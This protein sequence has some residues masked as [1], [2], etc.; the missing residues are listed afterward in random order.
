[1]LSGLPA[2]THLVVNG[3]IFSNWDLVGDIELPS[4][5]PCYIR[6]TDD[7]KLLSGLL[8][9][10]RA[11]LLQTLFLDA[12]IA[13]EVCDL[14]DTWGLPLASPKYPL[15]NSFV[16]FLIP[17]RV[18]NRNTLCWRDVM[19]A[20]PTVTHFTLWADTIDSFLLALHPLESSVTPLWLDYTPSHWSI[21]FYPASLPCC[22]TQ[23]WPKLLRGIL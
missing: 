9:A 15:L 17:S 18:L 4:L 20:F 13:D 6:P 1:M 5:Q 8:T 11:S 23:R 21:I 3:V 12:F 14:A 16:V 10:M 2:L 7:G 19:H 22:V